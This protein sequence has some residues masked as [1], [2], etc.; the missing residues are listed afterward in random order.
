MSYEKP[1]GRNRVKCKKC[2]HV[3]ESKH[4]HDFVECQCGA[5]FVDGGS[6]YHRRGWPGG[7]MEDYIEE[8]P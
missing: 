5:V 2:E 1:T 7:K 4:R 3:I 6:D 8:M